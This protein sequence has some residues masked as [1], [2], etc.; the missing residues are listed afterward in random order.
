[1]TGG[2]ACLESHQHLL[3]RGGGLDLGACD[4]YALGVTLF[5]LATGDLPARVPATEQSGTR[6]SAR[7]E[8][9][10]LQRVRCRALRR[11]RPQK[12]EFGPAGSCN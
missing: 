11:S 2:Y 5:E 12:A 10:L 7:W 6:L 9:L 3:G 4:A 1:V 8:R